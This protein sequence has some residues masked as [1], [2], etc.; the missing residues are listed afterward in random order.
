MLHGTLDRNSPMPK[1]IMKYL[2]CF[3]IYSAERCVSHAGT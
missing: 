2:V 3:L 1:Q